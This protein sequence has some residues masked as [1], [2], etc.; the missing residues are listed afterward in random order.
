MARSIRACDLIKM[1]SN[2]IV[3]SRILLISDQPASS[4][5]LWVA[6]VQSEVG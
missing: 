2:V 4:S 5:S 1:R 3:A 6:I